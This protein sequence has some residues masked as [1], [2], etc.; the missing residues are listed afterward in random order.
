MVLQGKYRA[1]KV[2][3]GL[4]AHQATGLYSASKKDVAYT[5]LAKAPT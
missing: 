5:D 4:C 1:A 2:D 3:V